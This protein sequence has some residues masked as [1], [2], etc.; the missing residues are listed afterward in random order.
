MKNNDLPVYLPK[1]KSPLDAYQQVG[2]FEYSITQ[3]SEFKV[4]NENTL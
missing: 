1:K 2:T 3:N 4:C